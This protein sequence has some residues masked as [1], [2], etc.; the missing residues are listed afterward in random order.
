MENLIELRGVGKRY[1]PI[2]ALHDITVTVPQGQVVGLLGHN[3]AG[4]ST[5]IK[6]VLG[7]IK[8]SDGDLRVL[9]QAPWGANLGALRREIGYLP[10][11]VAFYRNLTGNEIIDY[12][13]KLKRAPR[14]QGRDLLERVGL[15]DAANRKVGMYSKGM[16]QRLGLAQA[17]L[18]SPRLVILDE[19]TTGL[20]PHATRDLYSIVDELRSTGRGVLISSHLLAELEPHIDAAVILREGELLAAGSITD[21]RCKAGLPSIAKVRLKADADHPAFAARLAAAD[22]DHSSE[23]DGQISIAMTRS[24]KVEL[25]RE[26]V[27][28]QSIADLEV[29]E[30]TLGRIYEWLGAGRRSGTERLL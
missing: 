7:L 23:P 9:G 8:A 11:S 3:G 26:L 15:K 2:A 30:P 19:P 24:R 4:K 16:R 14:R 18:G 17:L 13:A 25:I 20:D 5:L 28:S 22:L 1:G 6:L 10:E 27:S 12:F 21:L 29:E